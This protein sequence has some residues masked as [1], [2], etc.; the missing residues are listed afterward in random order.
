[1]K[2]DAARAT[3]GWRRSFK[4]EVLFPD[5]GARLGDAFSVEVGSSG[6]PDGVQRNPGF[7][8]GRRTPR[9]SLR[10]IRATSSLLV[11]VIARSESD[12]AIHFSFTHWRRDGLL[13]FARNDVEGF[14]FQTASSPHEQRYAGIEQNPGC[15]FAHPGYKARLASGMLCPYCGRRITCRRSF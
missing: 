9:I 10:S 2:D 4:K 15:R 6:S 11:T 14:E 13:R 1:M 8:V 5:R 7:P 12:E 3:T